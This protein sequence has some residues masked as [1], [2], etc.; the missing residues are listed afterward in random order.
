MSYET[1]S[2]REVVR[3]INAQEDCWVL[4]AVQRPY[5]WG[6]RY[7][8]EKY[9]CK[10][11]DSIVKGYPIGTLIVWKT[12]ETVAYHEFLKDY[13]EGKMSP[14]VPQHLWDRPD[15]WLVY[16]GQQRLQTLFSCLRYTINGRILVYDILYDENEEDNYGFSF[17]N[18]NAKLSRSQIAMNQLFAQKD[19]EK[20]KYKKEL[21]NKIGKMLNDEEDLF[22]NRFDILWDYFVKSNEKSVAYFPVVGDSFNE[23]KVNDIFQRIN[24]GG[25]ALSGADLLFTEIK[26][27]YVDFEERLYNYS[28]EIKIAT[29]YDFN[30]NEILQLIN[31]IV[32]KQTR[33][34]A[35]KTKSK[36][37]IDDFDK[38]SKQILIPLKDFFIQFLYEGF[39]INNNSIIS[40]KLALLPIIVYIYNNNTNKKKYTKIS[41]K[42]LRAMKKYFIVSQLNDWNTQGIVEGATRL[43][44]ENND[45]PY[46]KI[47]KLAVSKNRISD[48][49]IES[50][51][52]NNW[53]VLK[54]LTPS[55]KYSLDHRVNEGRYRPELDHIFPL[56]LKNPPKKYNVDI[57]WNLQPVSGKTNN[58]KSNEHPKKF[59]S[60]KETSHYYFEY[61]FLPKISSSDWNDVNT[62][63]KN[64]KNKMIKF[65]K[66]NYD[67]KAK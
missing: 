59:F 2:I 62:F 44:N 61:D 6:S 12:K 37:I 49:T 17:V 58:Y 35:A 47:E 51:E 46:A 65:L 63:I 38:V 67:I 13:E 33:I 23:D 34:D 3:N 28:Q 40:R 50:L 64:R 39:G 53:F 36:D 60:N 31:L 42:N 7:E 56:K 8:S 19:N 14:Q 52:N 5:V 48:V 41:D 16:D 9:I 32:K 4:P 11:F 54:V 55:R 24:T 26:K 29:G 21:K 57:V 10:L 66:D 25:V 22:E 20:T 43:V 15:K 1:I 18:K 45:F 27:E 30:Q